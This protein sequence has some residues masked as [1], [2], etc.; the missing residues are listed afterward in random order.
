MVI[1]AGVISDN[2]SVVLRTKDGYFLKFAAEEVAEKKKAAIG[3]R[4]IKLRKNDE[5]EEAWILEEGT[6]LKVTVGER[7]VSLGRLKT[8]KRDGT[9]TKVRG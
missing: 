5:V 7:E 1:A 4:G 8:A 3:V 9:G 2:Q 6:E